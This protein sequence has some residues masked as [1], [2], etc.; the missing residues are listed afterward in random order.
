MHTIST[1]VANSSALLHVH[2]GVAS[3]QPKYT[4]SILREVQ[5]HD[6]NHLQSPSGKMFEQAVHVA[7]YT[8]KWLQFAVADTALISSVSC[9]NNSDRIHILP[10]FTL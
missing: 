3:N 2:V 10:N 1:K 8:Y 9:A 4:R 5:S 7:F 6:L